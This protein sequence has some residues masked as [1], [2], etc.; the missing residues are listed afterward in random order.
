MKKIKILHCGDLHFDTPFTELSRVEAE[1]RKEDLR[2]TFGQI[3]DLVKKENVPILLI[4]GDLFDNTKVMKMTLDYIISKFN[5]IPETRIFIS[6]GNHDPYTQRSFYS[7]MDWPLNVHIFDTAIGKVKIPEQNV[8]VYGIGFSKSHEKQCLIEKFSAEDDNCINIMV[9]H[10][11]VVSLGQNSD[12]H[13]IP[14]EH[15]ENSKL[16]YLALGHR[17]T[18]EGIQKTGSTF[19]SYSG[20]PE[21][22]G[23]DELGSKGVVLGEIGKGYCA[24]NFLPINKRE[25]VVKKVDISGVSTYEEVVQAIFR[26]ITDAAQQD[27]LYKIILTGKVSSEFTIQ[28]QVL[29]EKIKKNFYFV[30]IQDATQME[31]DYDRLENEFSLKGLFV[32]KMRKKIHGAATELEKKQLFHALEIGIKALEDEEVPIE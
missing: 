7:I 14:L 24:L 19:W 9:L 18:Y 20:N 15:I 28:R 16:D 3:I 32:K 11:E 29:E 8:C 25:Y 10:G 13:P 5:E 4:S 17:H 27:N 23:F 12:Y 2:E 22:R 31:I 26:D 21:G 6:P 1:K 30:K